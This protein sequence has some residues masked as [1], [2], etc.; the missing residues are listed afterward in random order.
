DIVSRIITAHLQHPL[1]SPMRLDG[2][3]YILTA[4]HTPWTFGREKVKFFWGEESILPC[5]DKWS[6][7]FASLALKE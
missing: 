6:F 2:E 5:R 1:P 3:G 7:F 4:K